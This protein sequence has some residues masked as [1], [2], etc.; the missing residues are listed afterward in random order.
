MFSREAVWSGAFDQYAAAKRK[1]GTSEVDVEFLKEIEGWRDELARN[2]ALRNRGPVVGRPE[3]RRATDDRPRGLPSHG[4]GPGAGTLRAASEAVRAAGHLRPLHAATCAA[5]PTTST[6]PA[7]SISRRKPAYPKTPTASRRSWPSMTRFFKPILQSLYFAHG[8]PYHFGVLPVEI[9]GTVYER[10][11][12]KV[13]RLTAGHQAKVEEKPEVRKAGGVYYTP[14]YIVDYIVKQTVGRQIAGQ[15]PDATGRLR[16]GK[17]PFRVLDMACG[18][19]SFL[20]GAYQCLLDHCL[21][22]YIE[23]K[24]GKAQEGRL[25]GPAQRPLAADHR[26]EEADPDHAHLRRGHR[27]P[28]RGSDQAVAAAEGAGR[29][30]RPEPSRGPAAFQRPRPAEPGRQHQVRQLA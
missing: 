9:L 13:I 29:R 1:R 7:C 18:S 26:G 8:S 6:T 15:K 4:R 5:R 24:P 20:L 17:Q 21:K 22:W 2:I 27:P 19:G 30:D 12:G 25:Q 3:P 11:L 14:A 23:H 10:F 28:G 16:N